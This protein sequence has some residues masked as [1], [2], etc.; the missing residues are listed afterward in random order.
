LSGLVI[1]GRQIG[2]LVCGISARE[3][4]EDGTSKPT[5]DFPSVDEYAPKLRNLKFSE[6]PSGT[7]FKVKTLEPN[8]AEFMKR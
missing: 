5:L 6:I 8:K 4:E 2:L 1:H 7:L 3:F